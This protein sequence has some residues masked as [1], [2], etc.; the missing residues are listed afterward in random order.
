MSSHTCF[1]CLRSIQP[2]KRKTLRR[3]AHIPAGDAGR[4]PEYANANPPIGVGAQMR[5]AAH[6]QRQQAARNWDPT[7]IGYHPYSPPDRFSFN[8]KKQELLVLIK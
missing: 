1:L 4:H 6:S 8:S 3:R 5:D 2:S 7:P